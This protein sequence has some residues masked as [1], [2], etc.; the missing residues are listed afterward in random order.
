MFAIMLAMPVTLLDLKHHAIASSIGRISTLPKTLERLGFVQADPIRSPARAQDLILRHRVKDYR[1]GDLERHYARLGLEEDYLYAYGFMPRSTWELIH[2]RPQ[3]KLTSAERSLLEVVSNQSHIHPREL[4]AHFGSERELNGW[5]GYSK[6]TTRTLERLRY[7]GLVRIAKRCN[8][9]RVYQA[10]KNIHDPLDPRTRLDQLILKLAAI[11][12]PV[13]LVSL[14]GV[15]R[16]LSYASPDLTHPVKAIDTLIASGEVQKIE[17]DKLSYLLPAGALQNKPPGDVV[18]FLAPFDPL[19]W[20]RRRLQ[21][22]WD[23]A[24][25]FE[26][27]TPIEKRLYG[28]YALPLLWRAD[29]VG[30]VNISIT[31]SR[32]SVKPGFLPGR[33]PARG[34]FTQAFDEERQRF[35]RFMNIE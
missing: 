21:L 28:Y 32:L 19:V 34:V 33:K 15:V 5:G 1:A 10:V 24:Y 25:R 18:R 29:V 27:Y 20:D 8:G 4:D 12:A 17:V 13:P 2:P 6:S 11:F 3:R 35:A 31:G 26:A 16:H 14:R 30:W 7:L 9:V 22:F 23:W